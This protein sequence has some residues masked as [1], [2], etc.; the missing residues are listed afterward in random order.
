[1]SKDLPCA[2]ET[3]DDKFWSEMVSL[4]LR[5]VCL[6]ERDKLHRTHTTADLRKAGKKVLADVLT[7]PPECGTI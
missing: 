6:I 5:A 7:E 1:M 4:L 2:C 3:A